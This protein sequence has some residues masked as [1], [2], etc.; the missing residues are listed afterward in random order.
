[1]PDAHKG[2]HHGVNRAPHCVR[3]RAEGQ[4]VTPDVQVSR[5]LRRRRSWGNVR[6]HTRAHGRHGEDEQGEGDGLRELG[7]LHGFGL[8][9]SIE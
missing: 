9:L 4:R 2:K 5:D 6:V 1:M 7:G 8:E 3:P